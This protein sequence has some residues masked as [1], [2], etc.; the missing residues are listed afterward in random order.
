MMSRASAML[1]SESRLIGPPRRP[2]WRARRASGSP[3]AACDS[4]LALASSLDR[5][6]SSVH[7]APHGV[8]RGDDR[9]RVGDEPAPHHVRQ[10]LDV[11]ERWGAN[12]HAIWLGGA[13]GC[14]VAADLAA[15]ALDRHVDLA[16][17]DLEPLGEDLEMVNQ[18]LH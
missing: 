7:L 4:S 12:V 13:V 17:R 18:R 1:A 14:D 11:D 8:D 6:S 10:T 9:D 5:T 3:R 16:L 2:A 15:R